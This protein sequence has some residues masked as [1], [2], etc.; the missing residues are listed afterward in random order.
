MSNLTD[1]QLLMLGAILGFAILSVFLAA[2]D[3]SNLVKY[4]QASAQLRIYEN[5]V[6]YNA[7]EAEQFYKVGLQTRD[8]INTFAK[9][10]NVSS[11]DVQMQCLV[12]LRNQSIYSILNKDL[13]VNN[14]G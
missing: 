6:G 13:E 8:T 7:T 1:N 5:A 3:N 4:Q 10:H 9:S 12:L 11:N 2:D 14:S